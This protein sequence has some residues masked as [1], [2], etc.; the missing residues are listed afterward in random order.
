MKRGLL[1]SAL[2]ALLMA[3]LW[4]VSTYALERVTV[5]AT[6]YADR[7]QGRLMANGERYDR[8]KY[9]TACNWLPLGTPVRL[10]YDIH[11]VYTRVTDR[12]AADTP[13]WRID[14]SRAVAE[15]MGWTEQGKVSMEL[16]VVR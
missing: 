2:L 11:T 10:S 13:G 9:S 7:Y 15:D 6:Y 5:T 8:D 3:V 1:F 12:M 4:A 16:E 14:V